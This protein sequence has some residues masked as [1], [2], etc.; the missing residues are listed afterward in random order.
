[1][2]WERQITIKSASELQIM[3]EAG[4]INAEA[5]RAARDACVPGATT[6]DVNAAA[7]KVLNSYGVTSPFKGVPGPVPFPGST[8][9]SV[10]HVLVHGIPSK[11][12]VLKEGDIIS[13][14]CGTL[15]RGFVADS[16][17]TT[18]VG[19][20]S[21]V[22]QRLM[23]VTENALYIGISKMV[24]GNHTGD[25]SAAIQ[26]YVEGEGYFLTRKYTGHGV[27]RSMWEAPQVPNCGTAGQGPVLRNGMVI[28]IE[29]MVLIGTEATYV[30]K[31][32]WSVSSADHSLTAHFE[33]TI[34][35]TEDGPRINTVLKNGDPP[36][37]VTGRSG[38][39]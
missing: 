5:L 3:R 27:G 28:A 34:A 15:W 38:L 23:E 11:K 32:G 33:H 6:Y 4:I 29:P 7:E 36:K 31:D 14:D 10:N 2:S 16:A 25:I 26:E 8:C 37:T 12:T 21:D 9:T 18:G 30:H 24:A 17:F 13:V 1:M 19:K 39:S 35:V 20:I 22:A